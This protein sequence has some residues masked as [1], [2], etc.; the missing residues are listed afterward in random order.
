MSGKK[1]VNIKRT[2]VFRAWLATGLIV[3]F[4]M[5]IVARLIYVQFHQVYKGKKWDERIT[6]FRIKRDTL[7]ASR[8]SIYSSDGSLLA[9]SLP[10]YYVGIDPRVA[11]DRYFD[12]KIDSLGML[13]SRKFG[14][15]SRQE[16]VDLIRS[17]R[18][19]KRKYL[20]LSRSKVTFQDRLAMLQWPFFRRER[21]NPGGGK[22]DAVYQRYNPYGRMALRTVGYLNAKTGRGLV[23]LEA[24][25]QKE[26][27]GKDGIGLVENLAGGVKMP[28]EDGTDVKPEPGM[29]IYTTIDVNFQDMAESTLKRGLETYQADK[30]CVIVMEVAT[31]EIRAMANL[32]HYRGEYVETFN[33]A[34]AGRTDPGS[35]FKLAS[36][37]ALLEEKA[38]RPD[39]KV[40][41]GGG[42]TL[43]RGM[44]ITD[45][46]RGGY[47]TITAQEVFEKSSNV[48]V[49]MLMKNYFY[50]R[51]ELYL[52]YLNQ[53]RLT[54]PTGFHMQGEAQPVVHY[55]NMKGWS[56]LS[57][58]SIAVGYELQI[59]PLQMLTFYNAIA[60]DG[61]WV[62]PMIVRQ[63]RQSGETVQEF[64]P[65]VEPVPI[66]STQT[67]RQLKRM[68][69]GVVEHGTARKIRS[70][71]YK[72]AGKT[73][74][75]QKLINGQYQVGK[76]YTS[77]I[78]YFPADKPKYSMLVMVD[79][80]KGN[81]IDLLMGGAVSA[82]IFREVADRIFAYD[83]RMHPPVATTT[84]PRRSPGGVKA[85][86]A[87]DLRMI[88]SELNIDSQPAADGWVK[89]QTQGS[90]M[91]WVSQSAGRSRVPDVRG[92]TLRD[93][94]HLLENRG[95][96]VRF[97][98]IGK[99]T[100]QSIEP[101]AALPSPRRITL[102]LRQTAIRP[103]TL[104]PTKLP[105][106]KRLSVVSKPIT[107]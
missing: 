24:S 58:P 13:L 71:Y 51:P 91:Q 11:K 82:P 95:F 88:G 74:T 27:G 70:D 46:K 65:H 76:Y 98:G 86:F 69:E 34:L 29:D 77:F 47:G 16:Y 42:T 18:S 59:T 26:L 79:S 45:A 105:D 9:T 102:M 100:E 107:H 96:T 92:M 97:Q 39:Q 48:G 31:G 67:I 56:K 63:I 35:T 10:Y 2:I 66:C 4:A 23:G 55:P 15:R 32:S 12:D 33:H 99:V 7:H 84:R 93:A 52:R 49:H 6:A 5:A 73:G 38:I 68:L 83:I 78:G 54:K 103:D 94:L 101:G 62:R 106:T 64:A 72:I 80:P 28:I 37:A 53:F 61:K 50:A 40:E 90:R 3:L 41:T 20:L 25:F 85:G 14:D 1:A 21:K 43:Y 104:T 44:R 30:G 81:N 75:A 8:G 36:M 60:N 17:A 87:D 19:N 57:M 22:F 89:A